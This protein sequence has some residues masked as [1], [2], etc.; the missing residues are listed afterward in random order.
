MGTT[1]SIYN[2]FYTLD[3]AENTNK[4]IMAFQVLAT[5]SAFSYSYYINSLIERAELSSHLF[6]FFQAIVLLYLLMLIFIS[7][8]YRAIKL[9]LN[10]ITGVLFDN[11]TKFRNIA[12]R[13][14]SLNI[15]LDNI[16]SNTNYDI[17]K[18]VGEN[19]H[20]FF[21]RE[22][23][24][25]GKELDI[26]QKLKKWMEYDSSSGMA[27]FDLLEHTGFPIKI[28]IISSFTGSCP[29]NP[30]NRCCFLLGYVDGFISKLF[31]CDLK[32]TCKHNTNLSYCILTLNPT[33][34]TMYDRFQE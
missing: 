15:I 22:L 32:S 2:L 31:A 16:N 28:K 21:T 18:K 4:V 5:I 10:R 33:D 1:E 34:Q 17:G 12:L 6:L 13:D 14:E 11:T 24:L 3:S 20:T 27:K 7:G 25:K 8:K 30:N 23:D 26:N 9:R 19:F 29:Q